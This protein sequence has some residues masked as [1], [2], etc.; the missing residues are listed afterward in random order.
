M[1]L[2]DEG[3]DDGD[4]TTVGSTYIVSVRLVTADSGKE[5]TSY[6]ATAAGATAIIDV[7]D[8]LS[9]KLRARVGE[10]LRSVNGAP[11]LARVTTAS[12]GALRKYSEGARANDVETDYPKAARLLR[13]A[14][15]NDTLFAE[16]WRKLGVA[17]A[18]F[19]EWA[20]SD[21][22]RARAF[23]L[24]H[25]L[26]DRDRDLVAASYYA[27]GPRRD[28]AKAMQTYEQ[29][30]ARGDSD[31]VLNNL[32]LQ[33]TGR[34]EHAR[35]EA[36]L[37]A[38]IRLTPGSS[39]EY[40]NLAY[41]FAF[42]GRLREA[43]SV[44]AVLRSRVGSTP[45]GAEFTFIVKL[46]RDDVGQLQS[47]LDSASKVPAL[48]AVGFVQP[49]LVTLARQAGRVRLADARISAMRIADSA[50]GRPISPRRDAAMRLDTRVRMRLPFA[51]ELRAYET[52]L[53]RIPIA[54]LPLAERDYFRVAEMLA[55]AGRAERAKAVLAQYRSEIRDT[56]Q[57]RAQAS[58]LDRAAGA[59]AQAEGRW[60]DAARAYRASELLPDGPTGP[61][62]V[63]PWL[64]FDLFAQAGMAD[65]ALASYEVYRRSPLGS[66]ERNGPDLMI[67]AHN[68]ETLAKMYEQV[69]DTTRAVESYRDFIERWKGAD[70]EL[71]PRVAAARERLRMLTPVERPRR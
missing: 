7:A 44:L 68:V 20:A 39:L 4:V 50:G 65:S 47:A 25:R 71:Q 52:T 66:R 30:L 36:L 2:R 43:D 24:R 3:G 56:A 28:R 23:S 60:A 13:E 26:P 15:A 55:Q 31:L 19:G 17:L 33:L 14:V 48:N 6:R 40:Q 22:A 11:P 59:V 21:S 1:R 8:E 37:R 63:V 62:H 61:D 38:S 34:R 35:A 69:G 54:S 53:E 18:N 46:L 41:G 12:L 64:L 27:D 67:D 29:L 57:L 10:S 5:L 49:M 9:R 58:E 45:T 16:A 70:P 32:G 42:S 51:A